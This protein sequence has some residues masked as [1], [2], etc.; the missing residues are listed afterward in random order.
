M[1]ILTDKEV[2]PR[3]QGNRRGKRTTEEGERG[4]E[5]DGHK[6]MEKATNQPGTSRDTSNKKPP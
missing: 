3:L 5:R 6:K 2:K 4:G 1:K